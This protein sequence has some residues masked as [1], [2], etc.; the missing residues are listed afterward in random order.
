MRSSADR[1]TAARLLMRVDDGAFSSRLLAGGASSGVRS[2]VMEVLRWQG[3][4]DALLQK[5]CKRRLPA[6][7]P[8]VRTTLRLGLV[9]VMRLEVPPALATDSA[10]RLVRRL[11]KSSAAGMVN[12]VLRAAAASWRDDL[13]S[14]PLYERLAH[15]RWIVDRWSEFYLSLIH[16]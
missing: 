16:I 11:G 7:D 2:R 9:E 13:T 12:A 6:L 14:R 4:V 1:L 3:A 10:V 15:P 8:E 5:R